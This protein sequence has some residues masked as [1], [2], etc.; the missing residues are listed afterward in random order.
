MGQG[1]STVVKMLALHVFDPDLIPG[2]PSENQRWPSHMNSNYFYHFLDFSQLLSKDFGLI[3]KTVGT[4]WGLCEII[5]DFK[6]I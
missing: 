6:R 2:S 1:E 5:Q 4:V 3:C